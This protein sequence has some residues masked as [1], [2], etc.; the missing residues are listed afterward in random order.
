MLVAILNFIMEFFGLCRTLQPLSQ[1]VLASSSIYGHNKPYFPTPDHPVPGKVP[2]E[3]DETSHYFEKYVNGSENGYYRRSSCPAV[4]T[5]ANRGYINRSGRNIT[6]EEIAQ[7][8]RDI[9]NFGDDN[10]CIPHTF[11]SY[12][13]VRLTCPRRSCWPFGLPLQHIREL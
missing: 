6:Y 9:W 11:R 3:I 5:M 8:A 2:F 4:N 7:A 12:A 1:A 10:V 13:Q